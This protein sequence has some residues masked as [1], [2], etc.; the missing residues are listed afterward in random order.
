[1]V[2]RVDESLLV[3][4]QSHDRRNGHVLDVAVA[5]AKSPAALW[6]AFTGERTALDAD[7]SQGT[8]RFILDLPPTGSAIVTLGRE[9]PQVRKAA[10]RPKPTGSARLEGP[11]Q[12]TLT[13]FNTLPLDYCRY[14]FKDERHSDLL[15]I[16]KI[17]GL[18]RSR[19]GLPTRLGCEQ[20]P[21]YLR[22]R[23]AGRGGSF[24][25][26]EL[27]YAFHVTQP[28][29]KCLL[30]LERPD[31]FEIFCNGRRA[32]GAG[33]WWVDEDL[34]TV[35]VTDLLVRGDNN[36]ALRCELTEDTALENLYLAGGSA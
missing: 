32:H 16:L 26:L 24:G 33:G 23:T 4:L 20:Q 28:P 11:W 5:A 14:R 29:G 15:P 27:L 13:E 7:F 10:P 21:W 1:M 6:D 8:A 30:V 17:D 9:V 35:D 36:L 25:N 22:E 31:K 2:R 12:I 19:F 3:F 34:K 18:L